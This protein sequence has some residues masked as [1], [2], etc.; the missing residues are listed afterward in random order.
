MTRPFTPAS[1]QI[2]KRPFQI[3][4]CSPSAKSGSGQRRPWACATYSSI[5]SQIRSITART[6]AVGPL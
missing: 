4:S 2:D 5:N 6:S 1:T 3:G